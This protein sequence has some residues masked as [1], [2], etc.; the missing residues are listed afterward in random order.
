[1]GI[2][3]APNTLPEAPEWDAWYDLEEDFKQIEE[4]IVINEHSLMD[5][6][7]T[8]PAETVS[9]YVTPGNEYPIISRDGNIVKF[10][11]IFSGDLITVR[12]RKDWRFKRNKYGDP[13]KFTVIKREPYKDEQDNTT[14]PQET[15]EEYKKHLAEAEQKLSEKREKHDQKRQEWIEKKNQI[16]DMMSKAV[17]HKEYQ[18]GDLIVLKVS[19]DESERTYCYLTKNDNIFPGEKVFVPVKKDKKEVIVEEKLYYFSDDPPMPI[20]YMKNIIE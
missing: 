12:I 19:F 5:V 13:I 15:D 16:N 3:D 11:D 1:M 8:S 14:K 9:W 10:R 6:T 17:P 20:E 2:F 18:E 4:G 7:Y